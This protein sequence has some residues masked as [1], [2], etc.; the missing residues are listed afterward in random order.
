MPNSQQTMLASSST[1]LVTLVPGLL[2]SPVRITN[3]LPLPS[4]MMLSLHTGAPLLAHP[5][6]P[7]DIKKTD[8][9]SEA[10]DTSVEINRVTKLRQLLDGAKD[11]STISTDFHSDRDDSLAFI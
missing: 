3:V 9:S 10:R 5:R 4:K 8:A 11:R 7:A 6:W 2:A 1:K